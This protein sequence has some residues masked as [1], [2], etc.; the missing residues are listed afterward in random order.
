MRL[1]CICQ[2]KDTVDGN[3]NRPRI[4]QARKLRELR[5]ARPDLR[6]RDSDT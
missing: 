1:L 5:P 2:G 3:T 6:R 4:K